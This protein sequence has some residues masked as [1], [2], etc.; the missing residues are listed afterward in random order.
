MEINTNKTKSLVFN[1]TGRLFPVTFMIDNQLIEKV[2]QCRYLG[3][4][5]NASGSFSDAK[6][7]LYERG[8]KALF[9]MYKCFE[10]H[11]P[12]IKTLLH[13]FDHTVKPI[14]TYGREF[15]PQK[16]LDKGDNYFSDLCNDL[17]AEK[18]WEKKL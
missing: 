10:G 4:M 17:K 13:V 14:L 16:L 12:K 11:K 8:L 6:E 2:K 3:V 7:E 15:D 1:S 18:A 5:F 9:K